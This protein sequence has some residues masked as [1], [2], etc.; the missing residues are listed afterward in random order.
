MSTTNRQ[1]M[2]PTSQKQL[3]IPMK[4]RYSEQITL[5]ENEDNGSKM[6]RTISTSDGCLLG[7]GTYGSKSLEKMRR[8][9]HNKEK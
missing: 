6:K 8:S 5:L 4:K 9:V 7:N 2:M 1:L 3:N